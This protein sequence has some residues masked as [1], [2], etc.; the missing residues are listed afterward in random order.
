[1][2]LRAIIL[3]AALAAC[4]SSSPPAHPDAGP[5]DA[6]PGDAW[7]SDCGKPGDPG[8]ALGV[9]KFC[10]TLNDCAHN[11]KALLC[12]NLGDAQSFFCT[13]TC[14]ATGP[15]DQCGDG[16]TCQCDPDG[17]GCTPTACL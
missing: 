5:P 6:A 2:K 4:G 8:N 17:C 11:S 1:M 3:A 14:Q 7:F 10:T 16:A 12:S 13:T 9:G 15:A